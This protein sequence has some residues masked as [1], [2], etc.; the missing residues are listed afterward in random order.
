[1]RGLGKEKLW[2]PHVWVCVCKIT[3]KEK[4]GDFFP[5]ISGDYELYPFH[6]P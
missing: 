6:V 3:E 5:Y 4:K 2:R 1:M